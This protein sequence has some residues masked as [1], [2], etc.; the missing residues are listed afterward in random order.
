METNYDFSFVPM[1]TKL[2]IIVDNTE[3][4]LRMMGKPMLKELMLDTGVVFKAI[5]DRM[6]KNKTVMLK[7]LYSKMSSSHRDI[8][9]G[10][11]K[12]ATS[13][14]DMKSSVGLRLI[15]NSHPDQSLRADLA[16][17]ITQ[18]INVKTAKH[19]VGQV[20]DIASAIVGQDKPSAMKLVQQEF[21]SSDQSQTQLES[22][23]IAY[24]NMHGTQMPANIE[25]QHAEQFTKH[26]AL[27]HIGMLQKLEKAFDISR[28]EAPS[29]NT[30]NAYVKMKPAK[31]FRAIP[32]AF[33]NKHR[34][35]DLEATTLNSVKPANPDKVDIQHK[36]QIFTQMKLA[37]LCL[38]CT[39][40][41]ASDHGKLYVDMLRDEFKNLSNIETI[42]QKEMAIRSEVFNKALT[43]TCCAG[44]TPDMR[45]AESDNLM[46]AAWCSVFTREV[47]KEII[48][49]SRSPTDKLFDLDWSPFPPTR[50]T[51]KNNRQKKGGGKS[52]NNNNQK[53]QA[54]KTGMNEKQLKGANAKLKKERDDFAARRKRESDW[55]ARQVED[56]ETK[57]GKTIDVKRKNN[58]GK[59]SKGG[60]KN[61]VRKNTTDAKPFIGKHCCA[62]HRRSA[63]S[64]KNK[65][66]P[67]P[68][69]LTLPDNPKYGPKPEDDDY[70]G[71]DG[72][73][74]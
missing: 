40:M 15:L 63:G 16:N 48:D 73:E 34:S 11:T 39:G 28:N 12:S 1:C 59:N 45:G 64:C 7:H 67:W 32:L 8:V 71:E 19:L 22:A 69:D 57:S 38:V 44:V 56:F 47:L 3:G 36:E 31:N 72:E 9:E 42:L 2:N 17:A 10:A 74:I 27:S 35:S 13:V 58:K 37:M 41:I 14:S 20:Y 23:K 55:F 60:G 43:A 51:Q 24:M 66:C 52:Q 62:R 54:D 70:E 68:H 50:G 29:A 46:R 25:A 53:N 26:S 33:H 4:D 65:K 21:I 30:L 49:E 18:E 61:G 5:S 6:E